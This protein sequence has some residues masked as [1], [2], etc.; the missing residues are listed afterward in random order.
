MKK[1]GKRTTLKEDAGKLLLDMG[2][3]IFGSIF[4]GSI[5]RG[6]IPQVILAISGFMAALALCIAGLLMGIKEKKNGENNN[7]QAK[8]E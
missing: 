4:L 2:K 7:S 3:L 1:P 5:L 8:Q 6:E